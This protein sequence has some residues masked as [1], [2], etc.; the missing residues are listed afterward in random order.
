MDL[1]HH[2]SSNI[3]YW[4]RPQANASGALQ[5]LMLLR[6]LLFSPCSGYN[7]WPCTAPLH[8]T[9]T[10]T[11]SV[12]LPIYVD[13]LLSLLRLCCLARL[14]FHTEN[15]L[16][17]HLGLNT[18]DSTVLCVDAL[19]IFLGLRL[20]MSSSQPL[21]R[22]ASL[23]TQVSILLTFT[24]H[25]GPPS[26]VEILL[27]LFRLSHPCQAALICGLPT[28]FTWLLLLCGHHPSYLRAAT[29]YIKI[30]LLYLLF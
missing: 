26:I 18:Q 10:E 8:P 1:R 29:P 11:T 15:L 19:Y 6:R 20:I 5:A 17:H 23:Y 24:S 7:V 21:T 4:L 30:F 28:Q 2:L 3:L 13:A 27:T 14:P 22:M 25:F 12:V 16:L 9:W